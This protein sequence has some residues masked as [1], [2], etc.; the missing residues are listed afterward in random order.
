MAL[1]W[2]V[3]QIGF[4]GLKNMDMKLEMGWDLKGDM[5]EYDQKQ[6]CVCRNSQRINKTNSIG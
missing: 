3:A 4:S 6:F 5:D 2:Y 1:H